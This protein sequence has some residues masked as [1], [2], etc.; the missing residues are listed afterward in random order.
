MPEDDI[1]LS[2]DGH[3]T[4]GELLHRLQDPRRILHKLPRSRR[5]FIER[6]SDRRSGEVVNQFGEFD[7]RSDVC[8]E[9]AEEEVGVVL[10][11]LRIR[12]ID[13]LLLLGSQRILIQH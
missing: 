3:A 12:P 11:E 9:I 10:R 8:G 2:A 1:T 6:N 4:K 13:Q 5:S 7:A